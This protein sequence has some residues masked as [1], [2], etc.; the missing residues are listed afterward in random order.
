MEKADMTLPDGMMI[1]WASALLYGKRQAGTGKVVAERIA[2]ADLMDDLCLFASKD[3]LRIGLIGGFENLAVDTLECLKIKYP[4]LD[5]WAIPGPQIQLEAE[6]PDHTVSST[7]N[8]PKFTN[9]NTI[10]YK[11]D[12]TDPTWQDFW[13]IF[14]AKPAQ[15]IFFAFGNPRQ[16]MI[17]ESIRQHLRQMGYQKPV[18]L[19]AVGG[20]FDYIAGKIPRAPLWMRQ[21]GLEWLFRLCRQPWR[22]KRQTALVRFLYHLLLEWR[23]GL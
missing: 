16:E 11:V 5:G 22:I 7:L 1:V 12:I 20:T 18:V 14:E 23:R 17:I 15:L 10:S 9:K 2:G 19:M 21:H 8:R 4:G 13:D 3:R 6:K